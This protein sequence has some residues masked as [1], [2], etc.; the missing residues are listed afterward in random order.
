[1]L[2]TVGLEAPKN[3]DQA[4]GIVVPALCNEGYACFSAADSENEII[5]QVTDAIHLTLEGMVDD[6]FD[7]LR[8]KDKGVLF[9]KAQE[10]YNYCDIWLLVD[11]DLTAYT[12]KRKRLN[13]SLPQYLVDR[14]DNT[15]S[16]SSLY[17]DRSHFLA[18]ASQKELANFQK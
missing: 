11:I 17:R 7:I 5:P 16:H 3:D 14:I 18:I 13:I 9:Y 12:G 10:D 15:V 2:F 8:V 1:M 6:E 4:F